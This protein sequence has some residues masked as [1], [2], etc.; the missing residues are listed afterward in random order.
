[1]VLKSFSVTLLLTTVSVVSAQSCMSIF[2]IPQVETGIDICYK[3]NLRDS[4]PFIEAKNECDVNVHLYKNDFCE[5][6]GTILRVGE[7]NKY[8]LLG[9]FGSWKFY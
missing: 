2:D 1:M 6:S 5:G 3:L 4:K 7:D 8:H 9:K